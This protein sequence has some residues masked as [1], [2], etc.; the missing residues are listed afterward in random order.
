MHKPEGSQLILV[1]MRTG[2]ALQPGNGLTA[3]LMD[4]LELGETL[5][6][7]RQERNDETVKV[8]GSY[9]DRVS[10]EHYAH[11]FMLG[12]NWCELE[13]EATAQAFASPG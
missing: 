8:H 3:P 12:D 10:G 1:P 5:H 7:K 2:E 11:S 4:R 6:V 9:G 13:P